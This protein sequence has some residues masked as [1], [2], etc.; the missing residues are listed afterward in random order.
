MNLRV[1]IFIIILLLASAEYFGGQ[2]HRLPRVDPKAL[3]TFEKSHK[4]HN[5]YQSNSF[6]DNDF[7][8]KDSSVNSFN[9]YPWWIYTLIDTHFTKIR[10]K[11]L[12]PLFLDIPPPLQILSR[13]TAVNSSAICI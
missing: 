6:T 13:S 12:H 5:G 8:G 9:M 10:R 4:D 3:A 7:E 2:A 11:L 1:N